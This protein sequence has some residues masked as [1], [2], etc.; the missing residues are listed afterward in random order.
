[1]F[2]AAFS[3]FSFIWMLCRVLFGGSAWANIGSQLKLQKKT[4]QKERK[5]SRATSSLGLLFFAKILYTGR[6][7]FDSYMGVGH[8]D[9][10][11]KSNHINER[12]TPER[13]WKPKKKNVTL[14]L[15]LLFFCVLLSLNLL[16]IRHVEGGGTGWEIF[17]GTVQ[18]SCAPTTM[19][20]R[21]A[22]TMLTRHE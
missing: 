22:T 13:G 7:I 18:H 20:S 14:C 1:M 9:Y 11:N 3:F 12:K 8:N 4:S 10:V 21:Q 6:S 17:S 15:F 5:S 2:S 19:L 16:F